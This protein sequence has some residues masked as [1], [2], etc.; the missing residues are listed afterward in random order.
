M[1][2]YVFSR[3]HFFSFQRIQRERRCITSLEE[4]K[5]KYNERF[6]CQIQNLELKIHTLLLEELCV[7]WRMRHKKCGKKEV[8]KGLNFPRKKE[9]KT[10]STLNYFEESALHQLWSYVEFGKRRSDVTLV[11]KMMCFFDNVIA[12]FPLV[13][14]R[15]FSSF[16]PKITLANYILRRNVNF[17]RN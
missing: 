16:W 15:C 17:L 1:H 11:T 12:T 4:I 2:K 6:V 7:A 13:F 9:G 5:K 8:E 3:K 10:F 14:S